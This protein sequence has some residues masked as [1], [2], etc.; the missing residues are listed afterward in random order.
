MQD[1]GVI[2]AGALS[3]A[4]ERA[5]CHEFVGFEQVETRPAQCGEVFTGILVPAAARVLGKDHVEHPVDLIFHPPVTPHRLPGALGV[6]R[7]SA[8]VVTALLFKNP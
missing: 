7:R 2:P 1:V 6:Q 3:A 4:F 5:F 8:Q